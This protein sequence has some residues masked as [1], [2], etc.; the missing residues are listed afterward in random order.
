MSAH[1][2]TIR[3]PPVAAWATLAALLWLAL[4]ATPAGA[5]THLKRGDA[6]DPVALSDLDG[7]QV[8][9]ADLKGRTLILV[10]G[11]LYHPRTR[12]LCTQIATILKDGRLADQ[13]IASILIVAQDAK[14]DELKAEMGDIHWPAIILHDAGRK[15][16]G[17]YRVAVLP[18]LVVV[19]PEGK[20][21]HAMAGPVDRLAD[22][23]TDALLLSAGKLSAERFEQ[24]LH[25]QPTTAPSEE[26]ERSE[27]F[28]QLARQL[29][30][31]GMDDLAAEKYAEALS[32]DPGH[33]SAHLGLGLLLLRQRRLAQAEERF[34]LVLLSDPQSQEAVLGLAYVQTLRGGAEL[35]AAEK[36]VRDLL[37]KSPSQPRAHYLLGLICE[38]RHQTD[39]AAASFKRAAE[40]L[41]ER[42]EE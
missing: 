36:S 25:P 18:S 1:R 42:S 19:D 17:D 5:V 35:A 13:K 27:R 21:V 32:L 23:L 39:K 15:A 26:S 24:T 16:F 14:P 33:E 12:D 29:A 4:P 8:S 31:R 28:T 22:V 37:A 10:F 41:L 40:L 20:V 34:R 38:Q 11:E 7:K 2:V 30:R 9:T 6:A 3:R